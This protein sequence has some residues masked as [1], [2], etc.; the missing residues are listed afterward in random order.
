MVEPPQPT[1]LTEPIWLEPYPDVLRKG[2]PRPRRA[3][4]ARYETRETTGLAFVAT[5]PR[6]L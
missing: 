6:P 2:W 3:P 1:R 4:E 5:A